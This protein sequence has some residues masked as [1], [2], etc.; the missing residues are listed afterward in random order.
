[1]TRNNYSLQC[2]LVEI[3]ISN[4]REIRMIIVMIPL[5][6]SIELDCAVRVINVKINNGHWIT[7]T[8]QGEANILGD[9]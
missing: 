1:M 8:T 7:A 4:P 2:V 6:Q 9:D 3:N 5:P